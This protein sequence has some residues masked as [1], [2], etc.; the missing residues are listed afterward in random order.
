MPTDDLPAAAEALIDWLTEDRRH[1]PRW[2]RTEEA[3]PAEGEE[4][5]VWIRA[6]GGTGYCA[7]ARWTDGEWIDEAGEWAGVALAWMRLPPGPP[8]G[9]EEP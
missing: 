5:L 7:I 4:V 2:V 1:V 3:L 9:G 6:P 8:E